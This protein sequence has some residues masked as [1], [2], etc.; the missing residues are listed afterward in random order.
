[1]LLTKY[2]QVKITKNNYEYYKSFGYDVD[3]N[4]YI[5]ISINHLPL[6]SN[7][8]VKVKCDNCGTEYE[9]AYCDYTKRNSKLLYCK[10][11]KYIS[12]KETNLKRYGCENVFQVKEFQE[13]QKETVNR[14][15][16]CDNVFQN[17][18][19][20]EKTKETMKEK[21]G[22]DHP[23]RVE[24]IAKRVKLHGNQTMNKNGT[25]SCSSQQRY[26]H[27]VYGGELNY[28][29]EDFWLDI[30][31]PFE[32]IYCEYQGSGHDISVKYKKI[33]KNEFTQ[34]EAIRYNILK[35]N[36]LKEMEIISRNDILP[37]DYIL[38]SMKN[39]SSCI[40]SLDKYSHITFDID[41]MLIKT[42]YESIRY[43][44]LT[45]IVFNK[46]DNSIVT[47]VGENTYVIGKDT[48]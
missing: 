4:K 32:N 47:T 37:D 38:L 39:F 41:N 17:E 30:Y 23:M 31:F 2:I 16:G 46:K 14:I 5:I 45:P 33:S 15:Y 7:K 20:K 43:D 34:K 25:Q 26:L 8:K 10:H 27:K 29:F 3:S 11:C 13:K 1:M 42:K 36:G 24:E 48:V 28:L 35:T 22:A 12:A 6:G 21:Y 19:I 18:E 40:L 9:L 44:Y